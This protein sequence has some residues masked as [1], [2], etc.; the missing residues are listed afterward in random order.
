MKRLLKRILSSNEQIPWS[1]SLTTSI[2][3][4]RELTIKNM[5]FDRT[6]SIAG[7]G[8][9]G[10]FKKFKITGEISSDGIVSLKLDFNKRNEN[11]NKFLEGV[12]KGGSLVMGT[13]NSQHKPKNRGTFKLSLSNGRSYRGNYT[14]DGLRKALEIGISLQIGSKILWGFG[15][16]AI[17]TFIVQGKK[18]G[19]DV[20]EFSMIYISK[21]AVYHKCKVDKKFHKTVQIVGQWINAD[22]KLSG[23]FE[24]EALEE[25]CEDEPP[26]N[27]GIKSEF[28]REILH[29]LMF[30]NDKYFK[31]GM[32]SSRSGRDYGY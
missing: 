17:G 31:S 2:G 22:K 27:A 12:Y 18:I 14:R 10:K 11:S 32:E 1:G 6:G 20:Y 13:W 26:L 29:G 16:N 15:K 7:H 19:R 25:D 8:K 4:K 28:R 5:V 21:F 23:R 9:E 3:K 30:L 24:F